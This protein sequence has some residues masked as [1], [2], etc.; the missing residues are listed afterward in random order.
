MHILEGWLIHEQNAIHLIASWRHIKSNF[1]HSSGNLFHYSTDIVISFHIFLHGTWYISNF[2]V[3]LMNLIIDYKH[4]VKAFQKCKPQKG[5][6]YDRLN[7]LDLIF[8]HEDL[9]SSV[10]YSKL[11]FAAAFPVKSVIKCSY[12][13]FCSIKLQQKKLRH[14]KYLVIKREIATEFSSLH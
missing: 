12:S 7:I 1:H 9:W 4:D 2:C 13:S 10:K 3:L 5:W 11:F 6:S 14:Q 8:N